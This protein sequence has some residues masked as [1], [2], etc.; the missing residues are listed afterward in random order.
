MV[1]FLWNCFQA[2]SSQLH[3]LLVYPP[4]HE[5]LIPPQL[6][7]FAQSALLPYSLNPYRNPPTVPAGRPPRWV[8]SPPIACRSAAGPYRTRPFRD[9]DAVGEKSGSGIRDQRSGIRDQRSLTFAGGGQVSVTVSSGP[10]SFSGKNTFFTNQKNACISYRH[11]RSKLSTQWNAQ[12]MTLL[13]RASLTS[14]ETIGKYPMRNINGT[15]VFKKRVS[16]SDWIPI[17]SPLISHPQSVKSTGRM[18]VNFS[19]V[20]LI[21]PDTPALS[22][23]TLETPTHPADRLHFTQTVH[24]VCYS[25]FSPAIN[26]YTLLF[27]Y[28][29]A[30]Q[31]N[32][33]LISHPWNPNSPCECAVRPFTFTS[34]G[35]RVYEPENT[36]YFYNFKKTTTTSL[37]TTITIITPYL[38]SFPSSARRRSARRCSNTHP[39]TN[40]PRLTAKRRVLK[41]GWHH[42]IEFKKSCQ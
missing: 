16:T 14:I 41:L 8:R 9:G 6:G 35:R 22:Y 42:R 11:C 21:K 23:P 28:S 40:R 2:A 1:E 38:P 15:I 24:F 36:Y 18:F 25:N 19:P 4:K 33:P 5:L 27:I 31:A 32:I 34:V 20:L 30:S 17:N 12:S 26:D 10:A 13:Y 37:T 3:A 39:P 7:P 29:I